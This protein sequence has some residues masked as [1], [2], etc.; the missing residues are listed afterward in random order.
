MSDGL[1]IVLFSSC[2]AELERA[3]ASCFFAKIVWTLTR[4]LFMNEHN[5]D[6]QVSKTGG[7]QSA[8]VCCKEQLSCIGVE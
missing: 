4:K 8:K 5:E 1:S 6:E 7:Q 2:E 3:R